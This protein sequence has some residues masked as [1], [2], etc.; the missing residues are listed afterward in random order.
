MINVT[1]TELPDFNEYTGY[2]KKIWK[3]H[4]LTNNGEYVKLLENKLQKHLDVKHCLALANGTLALQLAIKALELKGEVITT[5]FTFIASTTALLWEGLTPVF[6]DIDKQTFN[7]DPDDVERKITKNTTAILAVHI[8][9]NPCNLDR[10]GKIAKKHK[11][12]LIYDAA[13]AFDVN[14]KNQSI[15]KYGDASIISFHATKIFHTIEGGALL[16]TNTNLS[17]KI[18]ILRNFGIIEYQDRVVMAGINA[19]MN[20]FQSA[21]GLSNFK[22]ISKKNAQR[23]IIYLKYISALSESKKVT[24]QKIEASTYNYSYMPVLFKNKV[25]RDKVYKTLAKKRINARKYFYPLITDYELFKKQNLTKKY[26]L[27]NASNIADRILCLPI[28]AS[29]NNTDLE[30]IITIVKTELN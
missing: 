22:N 14:Y 25:L 10:L 18:E 7:I 27:I 9:G 16:T 5:P 28:F 21:M 26:S 29:L 4:W 1:K 30:K 23:K 15:F 20:E 13:H 3:S 2:L 12:K 11:L 24:F 19:K 6:A 8:Y 17:K